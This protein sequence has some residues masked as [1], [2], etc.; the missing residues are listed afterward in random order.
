MSLRVASLSQVL[1]PQGKVPWDPH[2][3]ALNVMRWDNVG[4]RAFFKCPKCFNY[5]NTNNPPLPGE[6]EKEGK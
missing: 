6:Q 2:F 1:S 3:L 5:V 4:N